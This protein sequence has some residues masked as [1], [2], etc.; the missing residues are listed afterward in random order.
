[1]D[2][3]ELQPE[4]YYGPPP[5]PTLGQKLKKL[6]GPIGVVPSWWH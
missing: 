5:E 2:P 6:L 3:N 4:P 1:M